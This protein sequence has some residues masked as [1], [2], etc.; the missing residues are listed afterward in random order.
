M[1]RGDIT[2]KFKLISSIKQLEGKNETV[3]EI[4]EICNIHA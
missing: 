3:S 2:L 4:K 1:M